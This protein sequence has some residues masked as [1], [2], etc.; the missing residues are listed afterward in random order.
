MTCLLG[1]R[2]APEAGLA[3]V[4]QDRHS[5]DAWLDEDGYVEE[6]EKTSLVGSAALR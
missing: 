1:T 4:D 5:G 6:K 2:L 3:G